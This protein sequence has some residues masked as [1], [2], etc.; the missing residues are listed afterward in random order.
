M[1]TER[2]ILMDAKTPHVGDIFRCEKCGFEMRT[3]A[4]CKCRYGVHLVCCGQAMRKIPA[5]AVEVG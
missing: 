1:E 4:D 3:V 5:K 2:Q